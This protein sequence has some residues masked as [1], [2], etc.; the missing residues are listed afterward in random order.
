MR[1]SANGRR[2]KL[3]NRCRPLPARFRISWKFCS[4]SSLPSL[5]DKA[6]GAIELGIRD[7][8]VATAVDLVDTV[9]EKGGG[10]AGWR[11]IVVG[12]SERIPSDRPDQIGSGDDDQFAFVAL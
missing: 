5:V 6:D 12:T 4:P 10:I 1:P 9:E 11:E 3:C 8:S 7:R 2:L